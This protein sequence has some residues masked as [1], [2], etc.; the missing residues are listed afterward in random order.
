VGGTAAAPTVKV[1]TAMI[2]ASVTGTCPAGSAMTAVNANG[3][4]RSFGL[5]KPPTRSTIRA[6][7]N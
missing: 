2:Q 7:Q 6:I 5:A 1:N 3:T 4:Q